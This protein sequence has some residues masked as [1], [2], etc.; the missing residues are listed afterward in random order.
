M[1]TLK[2]DDDKYIDLEV[3]LEKREL[4]FYSPIPYLTREDLFKIVDTFKF[5]VVLPITEEIIEPD[6]KGS[7]EYSGDVVDRLCLLLTLVSFTISEV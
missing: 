7:F 6:E 5:K 4:I 1:L 3:D 2:V